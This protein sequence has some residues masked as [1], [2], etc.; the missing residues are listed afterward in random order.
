MIRGLQDV[1]YNVQDM[2]R[3]IFFYRDVLG[4]KV[5]QEDKYWSALDLGGVRFGLHW[6]EGN[7]VP[8]VPRDEHGAHTGAT[9]TL[10]VSDIH[11]VVER[12]KRSGVIFLGGV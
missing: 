12:L 4:L 10:Q 2:D 7:P 9:V 5:I 11:A 8:R 6:T 3:S 1:Y